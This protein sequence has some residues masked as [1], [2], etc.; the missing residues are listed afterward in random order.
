[1]AL[2]RIR[3]RIYILGIRVYLLRMMTIT[4]VPR[5]KNE[6]S[7]AYVRS[8]G[9]IHVDDTPTIS[10]TE[11]DGTG[12]SI[13]DGEVYTI[14]YLDT[15]ADSDAT[16][17]LFKRD[18]SSA[19][20]N[21]GGIGNWIQ[22]ATGI[23]EDS[24]TQYTWD[25]DGVGAGTW[26]I[27]ASIDDTYSTTQY[28]VSP[29]A[30]TVSANDAPTV[31]DASLDLSVFTT[32]T[33]TVY[34]DKATDDLTPQASLEYLVY[35][36]LA[37]NI[38]TTADAEANGT[39]VGSY[40]ADIDTL[41]ISG[42]DPNTQYWV[43]VV[44][45]DQ[46]DRKLAY[47]SG[48]FTSDQFCGGSGINVDPWQIC[49]LANLNS[50]R[51]DFSAYYIL[52][53]DIDASA[54][55]TWHQAKGWYPLYNFAGSIDGNDK[56]I[57]D[58]FINRP[59]ENFIGFIGTSISTLDP[60]VHDLGMRDIDV[61][62][63]ALTGS[64]FGR[65]NGDGATFTNLFSTGQVTGGGSNNGVG[66][67]FGSLIDGTLTHSFTNVDVA[68]NNAQTGGLIGSVLDAD[69]SRSFVTGDVTQTGTGGAGGLI[70]S[71]SGVVN[72][73]YSYV[74][75]NIDAAAHVGGFLGGT[76]GPEAKTITNSFASGNV[77]VAGTS[78]GGGFAGTIANTTIQH[79][80]AE[81]HVYGDG[82]WTGGFIG[83]NQATGTIISSLSTGKM[84]TTEGTFGD[85]AF[86]GHNDGTITDG[87]A[88]DR[89]DNC[90]GIDTNSADCTLV[91]TGS[92]KPFN[93]VT[94][95]E[96]FP[97]HRASTPKKFQSTSQNFRVR[98]DSVPNL[99]RMRCPRCS[100]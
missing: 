53:N 76:V 18:G 78:A 28:G 92:Y 15:D 49:T 11:P 98:S 77:K 80:V 88:Y 65:S 22:F 99:G 5:S 17:T 94:F 95:D 64:M 81:G 87:Y 59:A 36:S 8:S 3:V 29:G 31:G 61:T 25:T 85:G 10:L 91:T 37:N 89:G 69:I 96:I 13:F 1:M 90:V 47:T 2:V 52:N 20:C 62:G 48:T 39:P 63:G 4:F 55:T 68:G 86:A 12:D 73:D 75:G 67:L 66:G 9:Y 71:I 24:T 14:T 40:T 82:Q 35:L 16:I 34:W 72:I 45:K 32:D 19:D 60:A 38:T 57:N 70:S 7:I 30:L 43:Q 33:V 23:S 56:V 83:L 27:C 58:L 46:H 51:D 97:I 54:T 44:A 41:T 42:L 79:S 26:S 50:I 100:D 6:E 74:T 21:A 93:S 84:E